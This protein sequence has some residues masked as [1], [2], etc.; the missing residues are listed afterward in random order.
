MVTVPPTMEGS[1]PNWLRQQRSLR[2]ATA[3]SARSS[4]A[5]KRRPLCGVTPSTE[6]KLSVYA[7]PRASAG[8]RNGVRELHQ[9]LRISQRQQ[10]QHHGIQQAE[11]GGIRADSK[12]QRQDGYGRESGGLA[13]RPR[14]V[15]LS[16]H[17][18]SI[19]N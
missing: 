10:A 16:C 13:Q 2:I 12:R 3:A 19:D 7:S 4:P 14:G 1:A 11:D 18:R 6:E 8:P 17:N 15:A 9:L 5:E